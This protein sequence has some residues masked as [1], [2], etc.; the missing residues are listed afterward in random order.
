MARYLD[1]YLTFQF[2]G[3]MKL[4]RRIQLIESIPSWD[5]T[6]KHNCPQ[7]YKEGKF[8]VVFNSTYGGFDVPTSLYAIKAQF[9][10]KYG[11]VSIGA[12]NY[13]CTLPFIYAICKAKKEE[14]TTSG[15][16]LAVK[17]FDLEYLNCIDIHEYD[18]LEIPYI[19]YEK[20][21]LL[22]LF[23]LRGEM[24]S[25]IIHAE[26]DR[27]LRLLEVNEGYRVLDTEV[28]VEDTS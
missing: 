20:Y 10:E 19:N 24:R 12:T 6:C 17:W 5:C 18:G 4:E 26:M 2:V 7:K 9:V 23:A 28:F 11:K 21:S 13:R 14:K 27:V 16:S 8:G 22:C 3:E 25:D 15:C 1:V